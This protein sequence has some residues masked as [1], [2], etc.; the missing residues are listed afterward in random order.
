MAYRSTV[1]RI[2]VVCHMYW[3]ITGR[4]IGQV[5]VKYRSIIGEVSAKCRRGIGDL[6]SYIGRHT[7]RPTIERLSTE[8]RPSVDR[9]STEC[10]STVDRV[11][12]ECRSS[13]D[14][15][16]TDIAVDTTHSKHDPIP[17]TLPITPIHDSGSN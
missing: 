9:H 14:R 8:C 4:Y 10:R 12:T 16:S 3:P 7:Y 1:G 15:V 11:S 2:S 6:K 5:S 13:V 17:L